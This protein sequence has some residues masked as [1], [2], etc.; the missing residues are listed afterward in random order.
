VP[1]NVHVNLMLRSFYF[2]DEMNSERQSQ[3]FI[4]P[5]R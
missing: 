4:F 1:R 5:G 3:E 2:C